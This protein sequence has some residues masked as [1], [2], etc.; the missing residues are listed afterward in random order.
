MSTRYQRSRKLRQAMLERHYSESHTGDTLVGVVGVVGCV[1]ITI[2][3][4]AGWI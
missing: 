1:V 4:L 2:L 3:A